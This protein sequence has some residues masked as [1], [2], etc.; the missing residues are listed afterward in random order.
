[1]NTLKY[2]IIKTKSQYNEYCD[3]LEHLID[4]KSKNKSVKDEIELLTLLIETW[5]EQNNSFEDMSPVDFLRTLLEEHRLRP[6]DLSRELEI[7]KSLLSEILSYK[8]GFSKEVIRK[9]AQ[10]FK[11]SQEA[12]NRPY[13][14]ISPV[15]S[16]MMNISK[17]RAQA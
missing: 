17:Q 16:S 9:L 6:I 3:T 1:M 8:K 4:S 2:K 14:L 11:V 5:D 7:S 12:F 15:G 13:K 10:Y